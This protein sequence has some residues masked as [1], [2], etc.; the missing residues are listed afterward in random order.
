MFKI[1]KYISVPIFIISFAI[2]MLIVYLNASDNRIVYVYPTPENHDLMLYK[3]KADQCFSFEHKEVAC[4]KNPANIAKI[5]V[6]G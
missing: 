4:P 6:Q 1:S 2:G 3:D 5:P